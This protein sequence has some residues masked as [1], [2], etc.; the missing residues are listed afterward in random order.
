MLCSGEKGVK[1]IGK[2]RKWG[3]SGNITGEF[4]WREGETGH[5]C[6]KGRGDQG[7]RKGE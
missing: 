5:K 3:S 6:K 4:T 7:R 2:Y 1:E